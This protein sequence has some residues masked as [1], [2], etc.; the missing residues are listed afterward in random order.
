MIRATDCGWSEAVSIVRVMTIL[1]I[2]GS[3]VA[4]T[5]VSFGPAALA[6]G[7]MLCGLLLATAAILVVADACAAA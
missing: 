5:V 7:A 4:T 6:T 3:G 1:T 2:I